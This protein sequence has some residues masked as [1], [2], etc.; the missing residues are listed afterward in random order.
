V[1]GHLPR[2]WT[3]ALRDYIYADLQ[4]PDRLPH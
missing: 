4:F 1:H 2:H 3:K